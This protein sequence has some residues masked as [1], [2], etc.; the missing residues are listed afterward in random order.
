MARVGVSPPPLSG[1]DTRARQG[2]WPRLWPHPEHRQGGR[3][4]SA[5]ALTALE[6]CVA[7]MPNDA[8]ALLQRQ[9]RGSSIDPSP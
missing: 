5:L 8:L 2:L 4:A 6:R 9:H 7:R 3:Q 1:H